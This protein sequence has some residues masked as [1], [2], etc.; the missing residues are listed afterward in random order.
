MTPF[1]QRFQ[2]LVSLALRENLDSI[3]HKT[4]SAVAE[5]LASDVATAIQAAM[6]GV[7]LPNSN[8]RLGPTERD[9]IL[10]EA[11][12]ALQGKTVGVEDLA[13]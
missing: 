7:P 3:G 4:P 10:A 8:V 12:N 13:L 11:L 1:E 6:N 9:N 2:D 5:L